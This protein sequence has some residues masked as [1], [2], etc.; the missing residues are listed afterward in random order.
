VTLRLPFWPATLQALCLG[1][2]PKAR[3]TTS[4]GTIIPMC[5]GDKDK[6][7][8]RVNGLFVFLVNV[9]I[10]TMKKCNLTSKNTLAFYLYFACIPHLVKT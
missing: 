5:G 1:R 6:I 8:S 7:S 3:V 9:R 4:N 2:K 10:D